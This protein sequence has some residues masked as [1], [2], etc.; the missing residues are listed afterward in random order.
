MMYKRDKFKLIKNASLGLYKDTEGLLDKP[1]CAQIAL[2][3]CQ[4]TEEHCPT[5]D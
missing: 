5:K 4:G 2:F 1:N 3:E